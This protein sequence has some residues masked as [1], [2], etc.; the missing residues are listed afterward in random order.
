MDLPPVIDN[1]PFVERIP[2]NINILVINMDVVSLFKKVY[3]IKTYT[4]V[5]VLYNNT[6]NYLNSKKHLFF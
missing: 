3:F 2:T 1:V 5:W 6:G 4:T